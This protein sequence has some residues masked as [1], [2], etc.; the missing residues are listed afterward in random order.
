MVKTATLPTCPKHPSYTGARSP[1]NPACKP[2]AAIWTAA[3]AARG[4]CENTGCPNPTRAGHRWCS[5]KCYRVSQKQEYRCVCGAQ[6]HRQADHCLKCEQMRRLQPQPSWNAAEAKEPLASFEEAWAQWQ[7]TIGMMKDRYAGPPKSHKPSKWRKVV[8]VPDLHA[9]FHHEPYLAK[10]IAREGDADLAVG[11]GDTSDSYSLSRFEKYES[12]GFSTEWAS[13]TAVMQAMSEAWPEVQIVLGN[14]DMRL[15]RQ[16]LQ[17][18]STDMV[19]AIRY[20]TGGMLCPI[21]ALTKQFKNVRVASHPVSEGRDIAW[22][23]TVGDAWFGHPEK[24][25][26]VPGSALRAVEEWLADNERAM[27]LDRYRLIVMGHTH[28]L[29]MIP[30]RSGQ[31]L[32]E[33]GCLAQTQGYMLSPRIGGRPQKRGYVTFQQRVADGWTDLNSVRMVW[34]D[35]EE[36]PALSA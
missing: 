21:T 6:R 19:D 4:P 28:Q 12:L 26:K 35:V 3:I 20:M 29:A 1:N 27:R 18:C 31:L 10:L 36:P 5:A 25:S 8:V 15:E 34:L 14:H 7:K 11:I 24:F 16:L 13:V 33:C 2:C 9:P 17:R 30:W 32:V 22:F 23:T